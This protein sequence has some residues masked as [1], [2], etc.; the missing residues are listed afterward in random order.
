MAA[1][2][3]V[4]F[5]WEPRQLPLFL[6][7]DTGKEG[8]ALFPVWEE[9]IPSTAVASTVWPARRGWLLLVGPDSTAELLELPCGPA[10]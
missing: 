5:C 9:A 3:G 1:E 8:R 6:K 2:T 10:A 7:R 4:P